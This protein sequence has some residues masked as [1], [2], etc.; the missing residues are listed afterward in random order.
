MQ[1]ALISSGAIPITGVLYGSG[2]LVPVLVSSPECVGNEASLMDCRSG[3]SS[4]TVLSSLGMHQNS[5]SD[6]SYLAGV[7]CEGEY[8]DCVLDM[9]IACFIPLPTHPQILV[10]ICM[11]FVADDHF[12]L[13]TRTVWKRSSY[14]LV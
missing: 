6:L 9:L 8:S 12:H 3:Q 5:D 1:A 2:N 10:Y 4:G 11:R 13:Y 14:T 7:R